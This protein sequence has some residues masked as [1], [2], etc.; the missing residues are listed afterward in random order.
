MKTDYVFTR[1]TYLILQKR[2]L[3]FYGI[4][5]VLGIIGIIMFIIFYAKTDYNVYM[6]FLFVPSLAFALISILYEVM[7]GVMMIKFKDV[8]VKFT[9]EFKQEFLLAKSYDNGKLTSDNTVYYD[10]IMKYKDTGTVLFL[11]LPNK[12]VLPLY[13]KDKNIEE[14][15]KLIK[16]ED[17][18]VKKI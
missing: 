7:I 15:K 9:Y 10:R 16:I 2:R 3:I 18:P 13:S 8:S 1:D 12:K 5:A 4:L 17:I 14:I 11:Y 6:I